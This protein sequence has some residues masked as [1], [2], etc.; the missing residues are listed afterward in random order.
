MRVTHMLT[1]DTYALQHPG[2]ANNQS[3]KSVWTH[4]I[5]LYFSLKNDVGP[6]ERERRVSTFLSRQSHLKWLS[7]PD[8]TGTVTAADVAKAGDMH[9]HKVIVRRWACSVW[10]AWWVRHRKEIEGV[11]PKKDAE[12]SSA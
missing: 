8:F 6:D 5:S 3:I 2:E 11:I 7:P 12:S 10:K 4:L 9:E 1:V